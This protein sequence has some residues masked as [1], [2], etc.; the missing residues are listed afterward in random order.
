MVGWHHRLNGHKFELVMD[1]EVWCAAVPGVPK[2]Q[3]QLSDWTEPND[4]LSYHREGWWAIKIISTL[5]RDR[6][7]W[8]Q[9]G[10]KPGMRLVGARSISLCSA[11]IFQQGK[12]QETR[13]GLESLVGWQSEA[14]KGVGSSCPERNYCKKRLARLQAWSQPGCLWQAAAKRKCQTTVKE[15]MTKPENQVCLEHESVE[16]VRD[17]CSRREGSSAVVDLP[18]PDINQGW[19]PKSWK[20]GCSFSPP[21]PSLPP[22]AQF[23]TVNWK[24]T[25]FSLKHHVGHLLFPNT[26]YLSYVDEIH[27]KKKVCGNKMLCNILL[28]HLLE[29][30]SWSM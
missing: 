22:S 9:T 19:T 24:V 18:D 4:I 25:I 2:S 30:I 6:V 20:P 11:E 10:E 1:R 28:L 12:H 26:T 23:R 21:C 5:L 7:W 29:E 14:Q 15:G 27:K 13:E 17:V 16:E 8:R 3:T